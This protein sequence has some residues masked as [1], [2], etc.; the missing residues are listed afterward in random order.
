MR[1]KVLKVVLV[2]LALLLGLV[3][4]AELIFGDWLRSDPIARLDLPR[5]TA[6]TVNPEG[7]YPGAQPF[8]YRRDRWALRGAG[9]DPAKVTILTIGGSTTNQLF[10]PDEQTWQAVAE[11]EFRAQG[12]DDVVVANAGID[13]QSTVGHIK[14]LEDWFPAIP[15]LRPRFVLAYVGLNDVHVSGAWIDDLR[16]PD[17]IKRFR[18]RSA[19]I[20]AWGKVAGILKARQA[21]LTHHRVDYA[22][23]EWTDTPAE[24]DFSAGPNSTPE[25][26]KAR[27]KRMAQLIHEMGAVPVLVTQP[28]GDYRVVDGKVLGVASTEGRNGVD[29]YRLLA[30]F[31]QATREVCRDEGLLC[32]DLA[33]ELTFETGDFYD[34]LHTSP[35]GS[36]KIGR[37]LH[38]KLAGLV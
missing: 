19:I 35:S 34:L 11:R 32:L 12:R 7:L 21:K 3:V 14:S 10:L 1:A 28:R 13:G 25:A 5:G 2:N 6:V 37:W 15:N 4:V 22:G 9:V 23:V 29:N 36:E 33:R 20:R 18:Q 17:P 27:L 8:L 31:N 16:H 24:P 30:R 38:A 26:Y